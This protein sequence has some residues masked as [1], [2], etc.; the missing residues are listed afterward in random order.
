MQV[1]ASKATRSPQRRNQQVGLYMHSVCILFH[2]QF[3]Q[4][5]DLQRNLRHFLSIA[6]A[7][8][9]NTIYRNRPVWAANDVKYLTETA[10]QVFKSVPSAK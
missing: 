7:G 3:I 9:L 4:Q 8:D 5:Q 10:L 6:S 1:D 2:C